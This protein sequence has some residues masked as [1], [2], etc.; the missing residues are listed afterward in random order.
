MDEK[1]VLKSLD[2]TSE[3]IEQLKDII[4]EAFTEGN[5]DLQKLKQIFGEQAETEQERYG[6]S[7][8]GKSEAIKN[9]Q[10]QSTGTLRPILDES[11]N[12]DKTDNMIAEGDNLEVLKLW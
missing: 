9:I 10:T 6:L 12:F 4:P 1:L 11:I 3:K 8:A 2:V 5:L 7:W